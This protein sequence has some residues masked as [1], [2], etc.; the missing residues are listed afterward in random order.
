MNRDYLCKGIIISG[1]FLLTVRGRRRSV[2]S[3]TD[4][5]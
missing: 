5:F 1:E 4:D 3:L 2:P